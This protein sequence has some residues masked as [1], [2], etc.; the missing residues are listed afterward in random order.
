MSK[1]VFINPSVDKYA[2]IKLWSSELMDY[3]SGRPMTVMPKQAPMILATLTPPKHSF[4]YV[5]EEIED[6]DFENIGADLVALTAMT[7]QAD[8]AYEIAHEFRKRGVKVVIGGIHASV[9][10]DEAMLHADAVCVGEGENIWPALLED[11]EAGALK[12]KY[13]AKDFPPVTE[14]VSPR[15]DILKHDNYSM[16]PIMTT[17][18]CPYDCDFC[19]IKFSSGHKIRMKPIEQVMNEIREFEKFNKG[20]FRKS[21]Q[22]VDDNL[23]I[24][25]DFT[26]K[27]FTALKEHKIIWQGQ[28]TL[29]TTRDDEVLGLMAESGCRCYSIGFES[30]SEASL[31]EANKT[32][33]NQV[34]EYEGAIKNLIRHGIT[35]AGFFIFGFD[36]D[37]KNVF[38]DTINF[39]KKAHIV[40]P[41][42]SV[43]T[44][45]PGTR[46][47]D[48]VQSR[49]FDHKWA[50]YGAVESVFT[51]G[52]MTS[53]E[54]ISGSRW[55][56]TEA[57]KMETIKQQLEYF[58]SQGPWKTIPTMPVN[59]R[60]MLILLGLKLWKSKKYK[61]YR[62]FLF[63]A[64]TRR[65][66]LDSFII[67][68]AIV[69]N[70]MTRK[71]FKDGYIP[72]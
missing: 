27:L 34:E 6:I 53:E 62:H 68:A 55:A 69:F 12:P 18:G 64:A 28:G 37:E 52:K 11:F 50:H 13:E 54:L 16:F 8:R 70:D 57:A 22:F 36:S 66:S 59:E 35:P 2:E 4:V 9:L 72:K 15:V 45:Y 61:E 56:C 39:I 51:P 20:P 23:Y 29:N 17:K 67:V 47:Y 24:N 10:P 63:W 3:V 1:I 5:D 14:L 71:Y 33:S 25:R 65:K 31:K 26:I 42:F 60:I 46:V 7:V 49:I 30:I 19:S 21:Y 38:E 58:W 40:N 32:K 44:P 48:R 43:L 41:Y